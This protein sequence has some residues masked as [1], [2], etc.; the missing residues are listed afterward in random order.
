M[1]LAKKQR[2]DLFDVLVSAQLDPAEWSLTARER[3]VKLRHKTTKS[4]LEISTSASTQGGD[5][6]FYRVRTQVGDEQPETETPSDWIGVMLAAIGWAPKVKEYIDTP[7][8]W[9]NLQ[10]GRRFLAN[11]EYAAIENSRF[12]ADEQQ[13]ISDL[14]NEIKLYVRETRSIS[15]EQIAQVID[16]LDEAQD[17]AERIG[18]KDWILLFL[19][20]MFTLIVTG[21]VPPEVVQQILGMALDGAEHLFASGPHQMH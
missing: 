15:S 10:R 18:R 6:L 11:A 13:Q 16:K 5:V 20:L 4:Y 12:T 7:D 14:L 1:L 3:S 21:L 17:A 2:N 8:F 19:G 9:K